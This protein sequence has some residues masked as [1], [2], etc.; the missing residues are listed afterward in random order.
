MALEKKFRDY[1]KENQS[2][3]LD[4][5]QKMQKKFAVQYIN[6]TYLVNTGLESRYLHTVEEVIADH[7][8]QAILF[9]TTFYQFL[10]GEMLREG[11]LRLP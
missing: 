9:P 6:N 10:T 1:L 3:P 2:V 8:R 4:Q 5:I 7:E 11:I